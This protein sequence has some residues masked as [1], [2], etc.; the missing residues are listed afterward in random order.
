MLKK[1]SL[2]IIII[3]ISTYPLISDIIHL[4]QLIMQVKFIFNRGIYGL[5]GA[6]RLS[7]NNVKDNGFENINFEKKNIINSTFV[8]KSERCSD[9]F[10]DQFD[11]TYLL[12]DFIPEFY[13]I[14]IWIFFFFLFFFALIYM[15]HAILGL[16]SVYVDYFQKN[17]DHV[18]SFRGF[19]P[20]LFIVYFL[21][22]IFF[23]LFYFGC[24]VY[25]SYLLWFLFL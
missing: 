11:F 20:M 24:L 22:F 6:E 21:I 15:I 23:A 1:I 14:Y 13:L 7:N 17:P 12:V 10:I 18:D 2:A 16:Y 3:I 19:I 25:L 8:E 9:S 4:F 5:V